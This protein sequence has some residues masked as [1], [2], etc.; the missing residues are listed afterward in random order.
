MGAAVT[1]SFKAGAEDRWG[2]SEAPA[3]MRG[4]LPCRRGLVQPWM[5]CMLLRKRCRR[6]VQVWSGRQ[7]AHRDGGGG[8]ALPLRPKHMAGG[9]G[10]VLLAGTQ[11][12]APGCWVQLVVGQHTLGDAAQEA[13][14]AAWAG[15]QGARRGT[16]GCVTQSGGC[17]RRNVLL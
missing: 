15:E 16:V 5:A 10:V 6:Q 7:A 1:C 3:V 12:H 13:P 9:A 11:L 14:R 8:R 4:D 2:Q 17:W